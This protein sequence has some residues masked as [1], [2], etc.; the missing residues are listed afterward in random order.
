MWL[1]IRKKGKGEEMGVW[2]EG[3]GGSCGL[4]EV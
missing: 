2:G 1:G 4:M 3:D